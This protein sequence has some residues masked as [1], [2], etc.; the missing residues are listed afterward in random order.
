MF[1]LDI[2]KRDTHNEKIVLSKLFLFLRY[3]TTVVET[4]Q[5]N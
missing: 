1:L 3:K 2:I 5:I 4:N